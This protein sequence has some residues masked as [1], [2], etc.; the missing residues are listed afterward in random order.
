MSEP[1]DLFPDAPRLELEPRA[2]SER[3]GPLV[4]GGDWGVVDHVCGTCFARLVGKYVDGK[5]HY[6]CTGCG[7]ETPA[8]RDSMRTTTGKRHPTICACGIRFGGRD[9][10]I[11]CVVNDRRGPEN[12]AEVVARQVS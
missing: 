5:P 9:G 1:K 12:P 3:P 4:P 10:G 6:R 8:G 2:R 7:V 11:R